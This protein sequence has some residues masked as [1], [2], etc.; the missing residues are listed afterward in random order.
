LKEQKIKKRYLLLFLIIKKVTSINTTTVT[1]ATA[2]RMTLFSEVG[3]LVGK[4]D[5]CKLVE[6]MP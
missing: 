1:A 4:T 6:G 5:C 2:G 3:T